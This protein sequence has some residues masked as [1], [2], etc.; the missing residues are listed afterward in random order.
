MLKAE[1]P[2]KIAHS[3]SHT[4]RAPRQGEVDGVH[5]HF[6]SLEN[7][8]ALKKEGKFIETALAHTPKGKMSSSTVWIDSLQESLFVFKSFLY[9]SSFF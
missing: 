5:Y 2:D 7:F 1:F 6:T 8:D 9:D 3:V 4:T